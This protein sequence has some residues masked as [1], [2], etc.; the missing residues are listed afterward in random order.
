M[1]V[2][3][4]GK[5]EQRQGSVGWFVKEKYLV[6]L[7]LALSLLPCPPPPNIHRVILVSPF[8]FLHSSSSIIHLLRCAMCRDLSG[9]R[10]GLAAKRSS[11][12]Q[13]VERDRRAQS[14]GFTSKPDIMRDSCTNPRAVVH[15]EAMAAALV[16]VRGSAV[17]EDG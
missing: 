8:C 13:E 16:R 7:C 10:G 4:T 5:R 17:C 2:S 9:G 12:P 6:Q 15:L 11:A 14:A 1:E 3:I